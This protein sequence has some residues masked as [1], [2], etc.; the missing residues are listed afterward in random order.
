M[1]IT[2]KFTTWRTRVGLVDLEVKGQ[3]HIIVT[4]KQHTTSWKYTYKPK[5]IRLDQETKSRS[6]DEEML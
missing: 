6:R 3:G 2:K 4:G 1:P 5:G